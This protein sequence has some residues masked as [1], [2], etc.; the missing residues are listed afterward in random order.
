M[1]LDTTEDGEWGTASADG[2]VQGRDIDAEEG[3]DEALGDGRD[4]I[5]VLDMLAALGGASRRARAFGGGGDGDGGEN[6]K[7]GE[8][9][10]CE[11]MRRVV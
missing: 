2:D 3:I 5:G 4:R 6:E 1:P 8:G 7:G 11:L 9:L 10:H